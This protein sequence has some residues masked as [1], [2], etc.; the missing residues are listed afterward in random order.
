MQIATVAHLSMIQLDEAETEY[1]LRIVQAW[2]ANKPMTPGVATDDLA[3]ALVARL[4]H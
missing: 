4:S 1:L 3:R 2:L